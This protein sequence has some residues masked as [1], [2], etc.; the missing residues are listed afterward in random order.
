[1]TNTLGLYCKDDQTSFSAMENTREKTIKSMVP[2][3]H[4]DLSQQNLCLDVFLDGKADQGQMGAVRTRT[5]GQALEVRLVTTQKGTVT[6]VDARFCSSGKQ[7]E[8][9]THTGPR[10]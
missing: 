9:E 3:L 5:S 6:P 1:M 10:G 8:Q 4:L 7:P 2:A